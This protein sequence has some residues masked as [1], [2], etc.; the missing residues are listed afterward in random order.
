MMNVLMQ[1]RKVCNHPDL[2]EERPILSPLQLILRARSIAE[3]FGV[4]N[5]SDLDQTRTTLT[6]PME[7]LLLAPFSVG[8]RK[9]V[10]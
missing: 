1:L 7:R 3:H 2:F 4:G 5:A 9:S 10:V 8:D 6:S